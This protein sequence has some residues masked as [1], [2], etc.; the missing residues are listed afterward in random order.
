[1]RHIKA[2]LPLDIIYGNPSNLP[3]LRSIFSPKFFDKVLSDFSDAR[4][5]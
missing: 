5:C 1:M 3:N 2:D 4:R